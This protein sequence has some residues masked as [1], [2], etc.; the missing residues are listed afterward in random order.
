MIPPKV[1]SSE[2]TERNFGQLVPAPKGRCPRTP[3][4]C[5]N[6]GTLGTPLTG[7]RYG[8]FSAP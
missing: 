2:A 8:G 3:D 7:V 4:L 1:V 6:F 5:A